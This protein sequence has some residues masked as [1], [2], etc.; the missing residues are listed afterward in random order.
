MNKR[1]FWGLLGSLGAGAT[2]MYFLDPDRGARRRA[3]LSDKVSSSMRQLPRAARVTKQD[4]AN[5]VHGVWAEAQHLFTFDEAS[6][7]VI[8]AR[9][10]SKMGRIVS[11]PHP[12]KVSCRDGIISLS[13]P[14]FADEVARLMKSTKCV[15][16]VKSIE[17]NLEPHESAEGVPALEGGSRRERRTEFLQ[18]HWSPTARLVA[19]SAGT[20]A[21]AY[22]LL[23][24]NALS[25]SIGTL[26][27]AVLAKSATNLEIQRLLG[28]ERGRDSATAPKTGE[29]AKNEELLELGQSPGD[30]DPKFDNLR[31]DS[32]H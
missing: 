3:I 12:I 15:A 18:E 14:I 28:L 6:D 19:G 32:V 11:H 4:L 16:G 1:V 8:E 5:R 2:A 29:N 31:A 25:I 26:G 24:R 17:N 23:K 7:E 20:A 21:L 27:A 30:E 10:R 13:G 22:G 9:V